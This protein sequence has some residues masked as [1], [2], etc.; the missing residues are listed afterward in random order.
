MLNSLI[1][2]LASLI[3]AALGRFAKLIFN[4]DKPETKSL[5]LRVVFSMMPSFNGI[6]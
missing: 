4:P 3:L 1:S 5:M 6:Y 2:I